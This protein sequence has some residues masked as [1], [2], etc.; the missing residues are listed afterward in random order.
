MKIGFIGLG[1][2]GSCM[3]ANLAKSGNNLLVY[4]RTKEKAS[5]LLKNNNVEW[6]NFPEDVGKNTNIIITMLSDPN[7]VRETALGKKGFLDKLEKESVWIDCSTVNPSFSV[8]MSKEAGN[9]GIHFIDAPV[10]G[11][12]GPAERGELLFYAGGS[13]EI[14]KKYEFLFNA[15]GKKIIYAGENGK[16]TS[17][18]MINNLL[19]GEAITAFAEALTL[20]ESLGID[21][22]LLLD[23][24]SESPVTPPFIKLKRTKFETDKFDTEFPLRLMDKDFSL[25]LKTAAEC[26]LELESLGSTASVF[27]EAVGMGFGEEDFSAIYKFIKENKKYD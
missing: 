27:N 1:I 18:K 9:R 6:M 24:F 22:K 26:Q 10:S 4:N 19:L 20:G 23:V 17:M 7:A 8:E 13:E 16:G 12:I 21:K 5:E 2:M 11:S 15:M 14:I 25:V 3:A